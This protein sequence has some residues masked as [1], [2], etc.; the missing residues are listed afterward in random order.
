MG[1]QLLIGAVPLAVAAYIF[2]TPSSIDW[3]ANF[4]L[5]LVG[6]S[7]FGSSL[8]YWM[9]SA[10]L[11]TT[12]LNRANAFSFLVPAFGLAMGAMFFGERIG[13]LE[14]A[15]IGLT[16]AGIA[17][18]NRENVTKKAVERPRAECTQVADPQSP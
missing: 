3:S 10:I 6:L 12:E 17:L 14:F 18:A 1:A 16:V 2:E 13:W 8:A 9:W 7:L 15:G 11:R 4:L 5:I